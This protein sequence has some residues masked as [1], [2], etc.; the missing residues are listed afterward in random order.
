MAEW[1]ALYEQH[2][3]NMTEAVASDLETR[4]NE[5]K[6]LDAQLKQ[7]EALERTADENAAELKRLNEEPASAPRFPGRKAGEVEFEGFK[8]AG[9]TVIDRKTLAAVYE[10]GELGLDRKQLEAISTV[11]YKRSYRSYLR[12]G[13]E[14]LTSGERKTLREGVDESG[15]FLVPDD[16][17]AGIVQRRPTPTRIAGR[18]EQ[19]QTSRDNLGIT[20]VNYSADNK[21]TT[22]MR[23]TWTGEVPTSNTQHRVTDP[24]FGQVR[25]PIFTAMMSL[26]L[27]LDMIE[28]SAFPIVTWASGKFTETVELLKD[29]MVINGS[30]VGQPDGILLNPDGANQPA[31]VKTGDANL[32]TGD[33]LIDLT[34]ALPEQY[35]DENAVLIFNK[36]N[37]GKAIRKLKDSDNRPLVSYGAGDSGLAGG[38]FKEV[39][40]YSYLWSGF[41]P[42]VAAN[43]F[44]IIFGDPKGYYLVNRVGFSIQVLR[45]RY[46]EENQVVLLGRVR[47]G[48]KVVEDWRLK[49]QK[50]A[51]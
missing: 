22:G 51:A 34:E 48:G 32:L 25:I 29:D 39:N 37:T 30:G 8:D 11:D 42:D 5:I 33:G 50:V 1:N 12:K 4:N 20:R 26:P 31:V 6:A 3:A 2:S 36:T 46:A 47:F 18:T 10:E 35:D 41:M 13:F 9:S 19:L 23:V 43:A 21:Y 7:A 45:E 17:M 28:D 14:N 27:T 24:V 49:V 44:P 15:G 38:R 40:G 16:I